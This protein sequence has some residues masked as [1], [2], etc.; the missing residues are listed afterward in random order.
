M[1]FDHKT[2]LASIIERDYHLLPVINRFGIK[3]GFGDLTVEQVC[4]QN[5]INQDFFIQI[6]NTFS[7]EEYFPEEH[8]IEF[9]IKEIV[10]FLLKSHNFFLEYRLAKMEQIL[11]EILKKTDKKDNF[12][13]EILQKF[14][15]EFQKE[16]FEHIRYEEKEIFP[17]ILKIN[18]LHKQEITEFN[19]DLFIDDYFK[20]HCGVE[21]K[22]S[23]MKKI[24]IK[25]LPHSADNFL[26]FEFIELISDF[27][28]DLEKHQRIEERVLLP[29]AKK[30][31]QEL[32]NA[33][34]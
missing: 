5:N 24:F 31:E 2:K 34:N 25:Y 1:F 3:L 15:A 28:K 26:A 32:L 14:F 33:K 18:L 17:Y 29:K 16:L 20:Q 7:F 6:I 22:I 11:K 9:T 30:I 4:K 12:K 13:I 10:N 21:N 27:E 19:T 8:L 23:D